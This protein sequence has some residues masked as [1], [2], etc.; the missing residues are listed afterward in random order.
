[1]PFVS[2]VSSDNVMHKTSTVLIFIDL[3]ME[4]ALILINYN[5]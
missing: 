5:K 4:K 3:V 2:G 1:M